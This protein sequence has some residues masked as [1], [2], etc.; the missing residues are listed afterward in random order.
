MAK[1]RKVPRPQLC[2]LKPRRFRAM[3]ADQ[4]MNIWARLGASAPGHSRVNSMIKGLVSNLAAAK[5]SQ[6]IYKDDP[7]QRRRS[8]EVYM[9]IVRTIEKD[10][11][12][13]QA[14]ACRR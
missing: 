11:A 6:T 2:K 12:R 4:L 13:E 7:A 3:S 1:R 5:S 8:M 9:H 14:K 10:I